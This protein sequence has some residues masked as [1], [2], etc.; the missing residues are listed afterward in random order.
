[1]KLNDDISTVTWSYAQVEATKH[2]VDQ[3]EAHYTAYTDVLWAVA[4][5]TNPTFTDME[6]EDFMYL[7]RIHTDTKTSSS[8]TRDGQQ[9]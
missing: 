9:S 7:Y 5:R 1:M 8:F 6:S 3:I 4:R 2:V